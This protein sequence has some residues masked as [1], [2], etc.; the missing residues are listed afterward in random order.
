VTAPEHTEP[1]ASPWP[2]QLAAIRARP[3]MYLGSQSHR[4]LRSLIGELLDNSVEEA[5]AGRATAI[6]VALHAD[7]SL[8]VTDD[9]GGIGPGATPG[10]EADLV[11][12]FTCLSL[13]NR[14]RRPRL[15]RGAGF[16]GAAA[17]N[18]VSSWFEVITRSAGRGQAHRFVQ[19]ELASGPPVLA[20]HPGESGTT[21]RFLPDPT[22]FGES[23]WSADWIDK[24]LRTLACLVP[25]VGFTLLQEDTGRFVEHRSTRGL[26][27][28][29]ELL[30]VGRDTWNEPVAVRH[31]EPDLHVDAAIQGAD[32]EQRTVLSFANHRNTWGG[33]DHELGLKKGLVRGLNDQRGPHRT[34]W[35]GFQPVRTWGQGI[36]AVVSVRLPD[37]RWGGA[38]RQFLFGDD[39]RERVAVAVREGVRDA[40]QRDSGMWPS[41]AGVGGW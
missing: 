12:V 13:R 37:P 11:R 20:Q 14:P 25:G 9:G 4:G 6:G 10:G 15:A 33:G 26:A 19:G 16:A 21:V 41:L 32:R 3:A 24:R 5:I 30:N 27:E 18:A 2:E 38:R 7:G 8:S 40:L 34:R 28:L 36:A 39:V 35:P 31:R 29:V 23:R 1:E 22:V 17:V